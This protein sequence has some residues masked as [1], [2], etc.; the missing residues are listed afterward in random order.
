MTIV[1]AGPE[2]LEFFELPRVLFF[3]HGKIALE[4]TLEIILSSH[5]IQES[6]ELKWLAPSHETG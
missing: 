5:Y 3:L 2:E 4:W 1:A 6:S